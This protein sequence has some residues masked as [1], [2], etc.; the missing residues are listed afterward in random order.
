MQRGQIS[1]EISLNCYFWMQNW[2]TSDLI[3]FPTWCK[4]HWISENQTFPMGSPLI[5]QDAFAQISIF[6]NY[7]IKKLGMAC[8]TV[9]SSYPY[10]KLLAWHLYRDAKHWLWQSR[11][12]NKPHQYLK[13]WL[14]VKNHATLSGMMNL[15][16]EILSNNYIPLSMECFIKNLQEKTWCK[17]G[18]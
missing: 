18:W 12:Y 15:D 8:A 10:S 7:P 16:D 14:R 13:R 5:G 6:Y 9:P 4:S 17:G 2:L 1:G 3:K 11:C